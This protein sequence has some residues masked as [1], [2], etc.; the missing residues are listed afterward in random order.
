MHLEH[1]MTGRLWLLSLYLGSENRDWQVVSLPEAL[2][3]VLENH[4]VRIQEMS[5]TWAW[6]FMKTS[7]ASIG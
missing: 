1:L 5:L 7:S 4:G 6:I 2:S 3:R